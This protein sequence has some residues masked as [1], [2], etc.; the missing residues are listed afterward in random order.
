MVEED[1]DIAVGHAGEIFDAVFLNLMGFFDQPQQVFIA[2]ALVSDTDFDQEVVYLFGLVDIDK[3]VRMLPGL[4]GN[5]FDRGIKNMPDDCLPFPL[6]S[7]L[8]S[9]RWESWCRDI[10]AIYARFSSF[11]SV[12][13]S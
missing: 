5:R 3:G 1:F 6:V 10:P 2:A 12:A 11:Y 8:T 9:G 7:G 13:V 4:V